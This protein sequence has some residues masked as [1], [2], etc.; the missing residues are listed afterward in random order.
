M[1]R[2]MKRGP[3]NTITCPAT[4]LGKVGTEGHLVLDTKNKVDPQVQL[5]KTMIIL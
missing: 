1:G 5:L 4:Y 2:K 3:W